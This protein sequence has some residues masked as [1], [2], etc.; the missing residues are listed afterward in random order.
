MRPV[1][2]KGT[3][4]ELHYRLKRCASGMRMDCWVPFVDIRPCAAEYVHRVCSFIYK[5]RGHLKR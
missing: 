2:Q 1:I 4:F 3:T 5:N